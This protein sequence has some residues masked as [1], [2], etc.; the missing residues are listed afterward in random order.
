MPR[1]MLSDEH[2]SK[3][4]GMMLQ[5]NIYNKRDLRM[6]GDG[7]CTKNWSANRILSGNLLTTARRKAN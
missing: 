1:F 3:L 6:I 2:W 7:R 4:K 5:E